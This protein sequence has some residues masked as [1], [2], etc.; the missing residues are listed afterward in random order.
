MPWVRDG[1]FVLDYDFDDA[2]VADDVCV[3]VMAVNGG[4]HVELL[5][6]EGGVEAWYLLIDVGQ[7][8]D[9]RAVEA[10]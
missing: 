2:A 8:V 9:G 10:H 3:G 6:A 5:F 1:C 4:I 7:I